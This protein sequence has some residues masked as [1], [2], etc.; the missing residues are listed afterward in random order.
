MLAKSFFGPGI[1]I[2]T[3]SEHVVAEPVLVKNELA[4]AGFEPT[5]YQEQFQ[6][7]CLHHCSRQESSE[8]KT[9][10]SQIADI[11]SI[12]FP[13]H[14]CTSMYAAVDGVARIFPT[15]YAATGNQTHI[16]SVALLLRDLNPGRF[17]N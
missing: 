5:T 9:A 6:P 1:T 2:K 4:A 15:S 17:T 7:L 16:S 3:L 14:A 13:N 11:F 8:H 10:E 12:C